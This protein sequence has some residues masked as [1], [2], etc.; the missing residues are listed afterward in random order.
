MRRQ[1]WLQSSNAAATLEAANVATPGRMPLRQINL[2]AHGGHTAL[3]DADVALH[4]R[5]YER[6]RVE[7]QAA[8]HTSQLPEL[9]SDETRKMLND[10]LVRVRVKGFN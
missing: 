9:P 2:V 10:L 7:L 8:R 3:E 5:E 1:G 6:L 4:Q